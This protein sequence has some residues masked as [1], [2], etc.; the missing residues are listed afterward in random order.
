MVGLLIIAHAP[1]ASALAQCALHVYACDP[2]Y[3]Q[4]RLRALDVPP[5]ADAGRTLEQAR[6]L[7]A[8]LRDDAGVLVLTDAYGATPGNIAAQLADPPRVAVVA[9]VNLPMLL[10]ALC[11][12]SGSLAET[13]EKAL[14]GGAQGVMQVT[15]I[16]AQQNPDYPPQGDDYARVRHH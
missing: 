10:R 15:S 4:E 6:A 11:Y 9:G 5:G 7:A 14:A 2:N 12:R 13:V 8:E 1:L 3:A 16:P